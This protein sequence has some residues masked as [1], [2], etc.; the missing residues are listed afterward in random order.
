MKA[1]DEN[2]NST[3]SVRLVTKHAILTVVVSIHSLFSMW[4]VTKVYIFE[5]SLKLYYNQKKGV[6]RRISCAGVTHSINTTL[7]NLNTINSNKLHY[8]GYRPSA[9]KNSISATELSN[10]SSMFNALI[11]N[12]YTYGDCSLIYHNGNK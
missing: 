9:T 8:R 12:W 7:G 3:S 2:R 6:K 5:L 4:D 10:Q 11:T 1:V